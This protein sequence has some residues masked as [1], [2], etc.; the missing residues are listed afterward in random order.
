[1]TEPST[2]AAGQFAQFYIRSYNL[3]PFLVSLGAAA[4]IYL[5]LHPVDQLTSSCYH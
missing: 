4:W 3:G 1:M 5:G 2:V